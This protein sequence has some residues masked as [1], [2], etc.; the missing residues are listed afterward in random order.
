[1]RSVLRLAAA[2]S[3]T[4]LTAGCL[5][6]MTGG[7][8]VRPGEPVGAIVVYN[9]SNATLQVVTISRC[10]AMSHGFN[11]LPDGTALYPGDSYRFTVSGGCYDVQ[12]GYGTGTSYAVADFND[13]W[14]PAGRSYTLTVN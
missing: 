4:A 6:S 10:E 12:A 1:M 13:I 2:L 8:L 3:L 9:G 14:V 7:E 11:R 5:S